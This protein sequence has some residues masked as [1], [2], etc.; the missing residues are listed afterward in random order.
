MYHIFMEKKI[1]NNISLN[2]SKNSFL[3]ITGPSG[4]GKSTLVD[5]ISGLTNLQKV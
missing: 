3:G 5:L 4:C 2:I 1:L